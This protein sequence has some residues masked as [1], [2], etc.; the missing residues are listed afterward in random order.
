MSKPKLDLPSKECHDEGCARSQKQQKLMG[1]AL[2]CKRSDYKDCVSDEIEKL[3][4]SMNDRQLRKY[5]KTTHEGLPKKVRTK[6]GKPDMRVK[7]NKK[8]YENV[9]IK[10][11][12]EFVNE[13]YIASFNEN[14]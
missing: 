14:K 4:R 6:S 7:Q 10:T 5:A 11:Y 8:S 13:R 3:A 1:M 2:A 9:H 12:D